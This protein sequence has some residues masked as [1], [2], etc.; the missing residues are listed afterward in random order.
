MSTRGYTLLGWLVWKL[1]NA[2]GRPNYTLIGWFT[3]Q[4]ASHVARRQL[5]QNK[6][7][8]GAA[9]AVALVLAG[10]ALAARSNGGED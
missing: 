4:V 6:A 7:K 1:G 9:A 2:F 8:I 5:S 10:G 3:W